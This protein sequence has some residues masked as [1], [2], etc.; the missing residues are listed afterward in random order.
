MAKPLECKMCK[1]IETVKHLMFEYIV[2]RMLWD[3][4]FK[5]FDIIVTDFKSIASK[6]LC[7]KK[8]LHFNFVSSTVL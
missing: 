2:A 4:V 7:D 1:E 5:I 6:W 8:F 3:D